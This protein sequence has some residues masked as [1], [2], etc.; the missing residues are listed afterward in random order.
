M[1]NKLA[2]MGAILVLIGSTSLAQTAPFQLSGT[3]N[4]GDTIQLKYNNFEVNANAAGSNLYGLVYVTSIEDA[5][6]GTI[7]W[8]QGQNGQGQIAG[9]FNNYLS[10]GLVPNGQGGGSVNFTG[11]DVNLFYNPAVVHDLTGSKGTN[12]NPDGNGTWA[13]G[14]NFLTATAVP[15]IVPADPTVTL[16]S[17]LTTATNPL[18]GTG[19]GYLQVTGGIF[20]NYIVPG[21]AGAG[22]PLNADGLLQSNVKTAKLSNDPWAIESFD[23]VSFTSAAPEPASCL[24]LGIGGSLLGFGALRRRFAART[25]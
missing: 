3:T 14:T 21:G 5:N 22:A 23:P 24:L 8:S 18:S 12:A 16:N 9:Y 19:F 15:G 6:T 17:I 11:G 10:Q 1:K 7:L 25:V 13:V 4:P 20:A 2:C